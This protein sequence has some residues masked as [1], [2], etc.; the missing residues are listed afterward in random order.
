M[1]VPGLGDLPQELFTFHIYPHLSLATDLPA[2]A[3]VCMAMA[4][5]VRQYVSTLTNP[6]A[7]EL[8]SKTERVTSA[9][10]SVVEYELVAPNTIVAMLMRCLVN[11]Y[12]N[13]APDDGR[14]AEWTL[15]MRTLMDHVDH[16]PAMLHAMDLGPSLLGALT[17]WL[18]RHTP[19]R[20]AARRKKWVSTKFVRL[21]WV[22][23]FL[24]R[25]YPGPWQPPSLHSKWKA[26]YCK[27]HFLY[28]TRSLFASGADIQLA[29]RVCT[30]DSL[31][32][33]MME[34]KERE[35][36][37]GVDWYG[38]FVARYLACPTHWVTIPLNKT[39]RDDRCLLPSH[40]EFVLDFIDDHGHESM[41]KRIEWHLKLIRYIIGHLWKWDHL[42]PSHPIRYDAY[43]P[44]LAL[45]VKSLFERLRDGTY[46][47]EHRTTIVT[48]YLSN[49]ART[50]F[51]PYLTGSADPDEWW[52]MRALVHDTGSDGMPPW[53]K[54]LLRTHM[55][56]RPFLY[57]L[58]DMTAANRLTHRLHAAVPTV[59]L[60]DL[61]AQR[62]AIWHYFD[63]RLALGASLTNSILVCFH[64]HLAD[65]ILWIRRLPQYQPA[66][67]SPM[68]QFL[69]TFPLTQSYLK[70]LESVCEQ[71]PANMLAQTLLGK[72]AKW[73]VGAPIESNVSRPTHPEHKYTHMEALQWIT[74]EP[75]WHQ[76]HLTGLT[77]IDD[78]LE[79]SDQIVKP[80]SFGAHCNTYRISIATPFIQRYHVARLIA[81]AP[82][83]DLTPPGFRY[84][85]RS[86]PE[87]ASDHPEA[88]PTKKRCEA[89]FSPHF[90]L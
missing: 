5:S 32:A 53:L 10:T 43:Q 26:L 38:N 89:F 71:D 4:C 70:S 77:G 9:G 24:R 61:H 33:L 74:G 56:S 44:Y 75:E 90:T 50:A 57:D 36:K 63:Q 29:L 28:P 3:R 60:D 86:A 37:R 54:D 69:R 83:P 46:P 82:L 78:I 16:D 65:E 64:Q 22:A 14:D 30:S 85:K 6:R 34:L 12:R 81:D 21:H 35:P 84:R 40:R 76:L 48:A 68:E 2:V 72:L 8:F 15:L 47:A 11:K 62:R 7:S 19:A 25:L 59:S 88:P 52:M 58:L 55:G 18:G 87:I 31:Y 49:V 20:R 23:T 1:V 27:M 39:L 42:E 79:K 51:H 80:K 45:L 67:L 41:E 17:T 66:L 13:D 73:L